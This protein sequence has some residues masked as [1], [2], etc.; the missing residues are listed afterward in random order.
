[1]KNQAKRHHNDLSIIITIIIT[2][3]LLGIGLGYFYSQL[4]ENNPQKNEEN[5]EKAGGEW[6]KNNEKCLLSYRV[7]GEACTDGGQCQSG[8]CFPPAL[9]EEQMASLNEGMLSGIIGTCYDGE[10]TEGCIKQVIDGTV[11]MQSLCY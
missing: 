8:I 7:D 2:I 9:N 3:C 4:P 10:S 6:Q 11:S 1:M 5:C